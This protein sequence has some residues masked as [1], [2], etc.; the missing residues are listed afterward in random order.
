[1]PGWWRSGPSKAF[2]GK[3]SGFLLFVMIAVPMAAIIPVA[4]TFSRSIARARRGEW[5]TEIAR[6]QRIPREELD[7]RTRT[8]F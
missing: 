1:M 2:G 8:W 6:V 4:R 7:E 3:A 5:V